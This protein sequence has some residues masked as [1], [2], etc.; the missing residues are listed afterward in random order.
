M[1]WVRAAEAEG[2][3]RVRAWRAHDDVRIAEYLAAK[4]MPVYVPVP[5][6]VEHIGHELGGS[7]LGHNGPAAKRVARAWIGPEARGAGLPWED[8]RC[9]RE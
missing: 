2:G 8:L 7:T 4:R 6:P 1:A 3:E 9:V 5:H